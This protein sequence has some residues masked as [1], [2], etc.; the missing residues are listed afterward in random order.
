MKCGYDTGTSLGSS[1]QNG[2]F[3][4][5]LLR[6]LPFYLSALVRGPVEGVMLVLV[7]RVLMCMSAWP[8]FCILFAFLFVCGC[9]CLLYWH[10]QWL[11]A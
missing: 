5:L 6:F 10:A 9:S 2:N 1:M 4:A 8:G 3:N 7:F 11:G